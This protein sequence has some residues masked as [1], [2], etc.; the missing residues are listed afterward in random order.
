MLL[1]AC[2]N[3]SRVVGVVFAVNG[4]VTSA[5][6]YGSAKLFQKAWPKLL[7]A[8]AVEAIAER[9]TASDPPSAMDVER[10]LVEAREPRVSTDIPS[11]TSIII[12]REEAVS[13]VIVDG[14]TLNSFCRS[15]PDSNAPTPLG[16]NPTSM[17]GGPGRG[18]ASFANDNSPT[19]SP[20]SNNSRTST[21]PQQGR[22]NINCVENASSLMYESRDSSK[23][24]AVIHQTLI[25]K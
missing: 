24:N 14:V 21:P 5:E 2:R 17:A 1:E 20:L 22:L 13:S 19:S 25:K 6:V 12:N 8:A 11:N 18:R 9:A 23:Q 4:K 10:F 16:F 15:V 3:R 7:R